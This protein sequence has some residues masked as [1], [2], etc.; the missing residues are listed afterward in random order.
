MSW[1]YF[2]QN[3]SES[4]SKFK[5]FK[6]KVENESGKRIVTLRTDRGGEFCSQQFNE[7]CDTNGIKRELT[8]PYTPEQNGVA[9]RKNRT[10]VEMTRSM[11]QE[12]KLSNMFWGEGVAT[13]VHI[14]NLSPTKAVMG[15][16]PYEA[17]SNRKPSVSHLRVFGCVA[18]GLQMHNRE[19]N[20]IQS[21][22]NVFS[23]GIV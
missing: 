3:K 12:K 23:L 21:L 4:F 2:L 22:K 9:E 14:L 15:M 1:V 10:V 11:L 8:A 5:I 18:Y 19:T 13:A 17:W 16:T 20:W 7:F 6:A